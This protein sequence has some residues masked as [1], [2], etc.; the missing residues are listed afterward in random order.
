MN[1]VEYEFIALALGMDDRERHV[2]GRRVA[3]K[4]RCAQG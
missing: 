1:R 2:S 4:G 3:E